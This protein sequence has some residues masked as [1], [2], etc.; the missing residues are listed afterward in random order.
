MPGTVPVPGDMSMDDLAATLTSHEQLTFEQLTSLAPDDSHAR[1]LATF[2]A[3]NNTLG[4]LCICASG[5][6]GTGTKLFTT[7]AFIHGEKAKIDVYRQS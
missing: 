6:T 3:Q 7:S 4:E 1:N 5:T 2:V